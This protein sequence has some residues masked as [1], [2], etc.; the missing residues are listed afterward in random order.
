MAAA[1]F[2][3]LKAYE[4]GLRAEGDACLGAAIGRNLFRGRAVGEETLGNLAKYARLSYTELGKRS[5]AELM[6]G[7]FDPNPFPAR[8]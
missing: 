7:R 3:R 1:F 6:A 8:P 4:E 2:G 5:A